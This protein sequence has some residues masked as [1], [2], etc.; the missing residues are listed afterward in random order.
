MEEFI[1]NNR[2]A[3]DM[4]EPPG[5]LWTKVEKRL[6]GSRRRKGVHV[7]LRRAATILIIFSLAF[8]LSEYIH[9][10]IH[11]QRV[12]SARSREPEIPAELRET[13]F[14]YE[15]RVQTKLLEMKPLFIAYPVLR[16]EVNRDFTQLDSICREL[17][18]DLKDN[19]A[20]QQVIEAMIENYRT[21]LSILETMLSE[22]KQKNASHEKTRI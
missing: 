13:K 15:T 19:V 20:N 8:L 16:D 11:K 4:H 7:W 14:Y 6:A 10:P 5:D 18:S 21:K 17:K 1:R 2:D 3:F 9:R 22:L 12:I